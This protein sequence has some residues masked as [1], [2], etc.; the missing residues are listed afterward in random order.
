M[1]KSTSVLAYE[2]L[3]ATGK[4]SE[5]RGCVLKALANSPVPLSAKEC[6]RAIIPVR[7]LPSVTPRFAELEEATL[8]LQ[9]GVAQCSVSYEMVQKYV[10]NPAPPDDFH[11]R[12][13]EKHPKKLTKKEYEDVLTDLQVFKYWAD[14]K[15]NCLR[16]G[17]AQFMKDLA[18]IITCGRCS[19]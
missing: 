18:H 15:N 11:F 16:P 14:Q 19:R 2:K 4:I 7:N 3:I 12:K 5:L 1:T 8:I 13:P 6:H 10:I 17:T 9:D